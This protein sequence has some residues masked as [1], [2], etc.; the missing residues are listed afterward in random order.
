[1]DLGRVRR[2]KTTVRRSQL[3]KRLSDH[4]AWQIAEQFVTGKMSAA[5]ACEWL[6]IGRSRLYELR[7]RFIVIWENQRSKERWLYGRPDARPTRLGEEVQGYLREELEYIRERSE[8]FKG[9]YNFGMLAEECQKRFGKRF[10][11]NT[12]RRWAIGQGLFKPSEDKTGKP[13][14]RFE[15]GGVG[16]LFQHDSSIHAW[17][18]GTGRK[19]VLIMTIDDHSRKIVGARLVPRD[20]SWHQLCVVRE[21]VERYG[22]P[23]AYYTDNHAIFTNGTELHTQFGR[24]L[25]SLDIALKLTA[26]AHP[27]AKGKIEKKFDYFQRRV[28]LLCEKYRITSLRKANEVLQESVGFYNECHIHEETREIPDK[29][30]NKAMEDGRTYL[31]SLEMGEGKRDLIFGLHY[32]RTVHKDGTIHWGGRSWALKN[33]PIRR[34]VTAVLRPPTGRR[35]PHTELTVLDRAGKTLAHFV[36]PVGRNGG[37]VADAEARSLEKI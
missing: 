26:K 19:D 30:W 6:G 9:H 25:G 27:E 33:P 28:P 20:T 16:M 35:R 8:F 14:I 24:A 11:R 7:R 10:H 29:R 37:P 12:L 4:V 18:P 34:T 3:H 36:L 32:E 22:C 1:M 2:E 17:V 23:L 13:L 15:T 31:R 21:T 5:K